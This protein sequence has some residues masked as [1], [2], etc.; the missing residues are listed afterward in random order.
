MMY[1]SEG[2]IK[3]GH[4]IYFLNLEIQVVNSMKCSGIISVIMFR[5]PFHF[6]FGFC[7]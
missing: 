4:L 1:L 3:H 7:I 2:F 6:G 5:E